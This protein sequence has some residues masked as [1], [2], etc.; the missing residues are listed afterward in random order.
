MIKMFIM[1]LL[2][3]FSLNVNAINLDIQEDVVPQLN[4]NGYRLAVENEIL[5]LYINEK[6]IYK[7][8]TKNYFDE[9]RATPIRMVLNE[10]QETDKKN[11][12]Y[13]AYMYFDC[14]NKSNMILFV[15]V[16]DKN[17]KFLREEKQE[18]YWDGT[19]ERSNNRTL[20]EY[21]CRQ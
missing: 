11:T 3:L 16:F 15:H 7:V 6:A 12:N 14:I 2:M 19:E 5:Q 8:E 10:D 18:P 17:G 13:I 4:V 9:V 1:S 21:I 20:N